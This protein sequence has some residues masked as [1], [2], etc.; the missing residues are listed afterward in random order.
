MQLAFEKDE[1]LH[2]LQVVQGVASERNTL[3]I[4]SNV[5]VRAENGAIE[6]S[7]TDLEVGIKVTVI[8][9][10][11]EEGS[12][13]V[14]AKKFTDLVRELPDKTIELATTA[15]DRVEL[16]CGDGVYKIIGL[17]D[18]DFPQL[19]SVDGEAIT[20]DGATLNSVIQ[21][22]EFA[23]S[24]DEVRYLLNSLYFNIQED[25]TE[26]VATD[27][28]KQLA[29]THCDP[30]K[31]AEDVTGFIVP[32][33]AV[34][35]IERTF[36]DSPEVKIS[37]AKNQLLLANDNTTLT[38]RLVEGEYANYQGVIPESSEGRAVVAKALLLPATKRVALLSNPKNNLICLEIDTEQ[39]RVSSKSPELGEALE[40]LPVE[41][42]TGSVR[43][44]VDAKVLT[45]VV[46][47]IE[48]ETLII[49]FSGEFTQFAV[50]P[51]GD[52]DHTCVIMP[53]RLES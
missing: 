14:S 37:L 51:M 39:I 9:V 43:I 27:G 45:E 52:D 41:S 30:L 40:T 11:N 24:R 20:I 26:I 21:R 12:I 25:K 38:T 2:S 7:A 19:P 33:K 13:T 31:T 32:L 48:T 36:V 22:T 15:N 29:L 23:A 8:G 53:M 3:P 28:T 34:R 18:E 46:S 6:F 35:E 10:I 4:L 47:H 49:E 1:L 17:S 42:S 44:G 5:L 16:T 50:K